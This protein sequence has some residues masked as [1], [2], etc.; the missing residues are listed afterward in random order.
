[1]KTTFNNEK[2]AY[3]GPSFLEV[4]V[5]YRTII[6]LSGNPEVDGTENE[7]EEEFNI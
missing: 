1:M 7:G 2:K 6:C 5:G 4:S 3:M